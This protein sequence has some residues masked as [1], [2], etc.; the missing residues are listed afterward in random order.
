MSS[1]GL[2]NKNNFLFWACLVEDYNIKTNYYFFFIIS[3]FL[4]L[5]LSSKRLVSWYT[6]VWQICV[7]CTHLLLLAC[8]LLS[9][10]H[11]SS[12]PRWLLCPPFCHL[13]LSRWILRSS[14]SCL[15]GL[16]ET[17]H[18]PI[19]WRKVFHLFID[20]FIYECKNL[21]MHFFIHLFTDLFTGSNSRI[22]PLDFEILEYTP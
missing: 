16:M 11:R 6:Y 3:Y 9:V 2:S 15:L 12:W 22:P 14:A 8:G 21:F 4:V 19:P 10:G 5:Q 7:T 13:L 20:R 18:K 1:R 17:L